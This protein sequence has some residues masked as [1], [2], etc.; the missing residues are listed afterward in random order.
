MLAERENLVRDYSFVSKVHLVGRAITAA[1]DEKLCILFGKWN[2][3][4]AGG[5]KALIEGKKF[6]MAFGLR[7][8]ST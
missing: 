5:K 7:P 1:K 8:M 3:S 2:C 6:T 4:F